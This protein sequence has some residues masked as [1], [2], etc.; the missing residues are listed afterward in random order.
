MRILSGIQPSGELH[1]GN[2]FGMIKPMVES[3]K[4]G[5]LFCFV[6]N[7][8]ALTSLFDKD[9]LAKQTIDACLDLLA[10]GI[11][12]EK[13]IF[14]VQSDLPEILELMWYLSNVT[15]ISLL[16]R[17]HAYKDKVSKGISPNSGLFS[18]PVLMSADILGFQANVVPVGEDQKQHIEVARDIAIKFN[19]TYGKVFVL[20]E[21]EIQDS[22][23]IIPGLDGQKMSKS[24]ENTIEIFADEKRL[25]KKVMRIVTDSTP[26]EMPKD[27]QKCHIFTLYKLFVS[28]DAAL[29]MAGKYRGGYGYGEAKKVLFETIWEYFAPYRLRRQQ[30]ANDIDVL[31]DILDKGAQKARNILSETLADVRKAVGVGTV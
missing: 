14:W 7:L 12:P 26:L 25:K 13:T 20:P 8:H 10:L 28:E 27:P 3:Q 15:P 1:I 19:N 9:R 31:K 11:S 16:D 4:K 22:V 30:L 18:Y 5:E 17:C 29:E 23:A 24:Y 2:Y 6:A 21:A